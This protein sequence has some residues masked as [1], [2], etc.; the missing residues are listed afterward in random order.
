MAK[1]DAEAFLRKHGTNKTKVVD[2]VTGIKATFNGWPT[3]YTPTALGA[4]AAAAE[5]V[6]VSLPKKEVHGRD[7]VPSSTIAGE[8][9]GE[10]VV[11]ILGGEEA[12]ETQADAA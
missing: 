2:P 3:R 7:V 11:G 9:A 12:E 10:F 6:K 5:K 8:K 1:F 4:A